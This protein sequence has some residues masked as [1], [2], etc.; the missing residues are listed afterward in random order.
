MRGGRKRPFRE[1]RLWAD[2]TEDTTQS[3]L[4]L[5]DTRALKKSIDYR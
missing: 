4:R 5:C 1:R 2:D 3:V